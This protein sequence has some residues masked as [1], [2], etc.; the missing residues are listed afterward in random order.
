MTS[1][2]TQVMDSGRDTGNDLPELHID[3]YEVAYLRGG[4]RELLKLRL[5]ELMQKGCLIVIEEMRWFATD[6]L[7]SA[8]T[9]LQ[10]RSELDTA[11]RHL[12][13]FFRHPRTP[14]EI[15]NLTFPR[16]LASVCTRIRQD[17]FKREMLTGRLAPEDCGGGPFAIAIVVT[18]FLLGVCGTY[19]LHSIIPFAL[20][21][22]GVLIYGYYS[23][24]DRYRLT[25]TGKQHLKAL[26]R[27]FQSLADFGNTAR[28]RAVSDKLLH[29]SPSEEV[30]AVAIFGLGI[31]ANSPFDALAKTLSGKT[32]Q[33]N[34]EYGSA[35]AGGCD[36]SADNDACA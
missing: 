18:V 11:D 32:S 23:T 25:D 7:L 22:G 33:G 6:R 13:E 17:L 5:F 28:V 19:L 14:K 8:A 12:L 35:N 21:I 30:R 27:Q 24:K 29:L 1:T 3:P 10:N 4:S 34:G 16:E 26:Q 9:D 36:G 31:L 2:L 20:V 15:F